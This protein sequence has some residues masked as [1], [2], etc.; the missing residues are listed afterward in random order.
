MAESSETLITLQL[1]V[2]RLAKMLKLIYVLFF[3]RFTA[4]IE[5]TFILSSSEIKVSSASLKYN[6]KNS[7]MFSL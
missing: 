4:K 6:L 7:V 3:K 2:I 1:L 5:S